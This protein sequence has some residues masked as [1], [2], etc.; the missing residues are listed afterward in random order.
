MSRWKTWEASCSDIPP[1]LTTIQ[2]GGTVLECSMSRDRN[3]S[4]IIYLV[5]SEACGA[6]FGRGMMVVLLSLSKR[7]DFCKKV[8]LEHRH[9][10]RIAAFSAGVEEL[11]SP[12]VP[13]ASSSTEVS[14][15]STGRSSTRISPGKHASQFPTRAFHP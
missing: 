1:K 4:G 14:E 8:E 6:V 13:P 9:M 5:T 2:V 3:T 11:L 10:N 15:R 12:E 7:T